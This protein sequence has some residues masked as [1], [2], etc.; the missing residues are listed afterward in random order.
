MGLR[1]RPSSAF[2]GHSFTSSTLQRLDP[3]ATS[4]HKQNYAQHA[5]WCPMGDRAVVH[6][7]CWPDSVHDDLPEWPLASASAD[8]GWAQR[9]H[10]PMPARIQSHSVS[11]WCLQ[12]ACNSSYQAMHPMGIRYLLYES[13]LR[14]H[15][16]AEGVRS[17]DVAR[18]NAWVIRAWPAGARFC[19][20]PG[21]RRRVSCMS[22]E[23]GLASSK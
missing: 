7:L 20:A 3:A 12:S 2:T 14:L 1:R 5:V 15:T 18:G 22:V 21:A 10:W 16:R 13:E 17:R 6:C 23:S 11:E 19:R 8:A 9:M 4:K